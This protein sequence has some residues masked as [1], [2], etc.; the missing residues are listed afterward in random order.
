V[1][2]SQFFP[3]S[4]ETCTSPSSLPAHRTPAVTGDSSNERMFEFVST[5]V[6]S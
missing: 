1:T 2:F 6:F 4:R 5:P 3:P